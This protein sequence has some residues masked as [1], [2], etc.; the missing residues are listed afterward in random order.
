M[1]K[2][3]TT[4]GLAKA[5][6]IGLIP[7]FG[8]AW[9]LRY[10]Y[11][12]KGELEASS[13]VIAVVMVLIMWSFMAYVFFFKD[14]KKPGDLPDIKTPKSEQPDA[15]V[16]QHVIS[17]FVSAL[18]VGMS[19]VGMLIQMPE[20]FA[21]PWCA[22]PLFGGWLAIEVRYWGW[23]RRREWVRFWTIEGLCTHCGYDIRKLPEAKVCPECGGSVIQ[24]KPQETAS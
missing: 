6:F 15:N 10:E 22:M 2:R 1:P 8:A 3:K 24:D 14:R 19:I 13:V 18:A 4:L 12:E 17:T 5:I 7:V 9:A 23:G 20:M 11:R 21:K 16:L